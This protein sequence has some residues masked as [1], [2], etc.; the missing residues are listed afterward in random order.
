MCILTAVLVVPNAMRNGRRR[1]VLRR[2]K[3]ASEL[4]ITVVG[5]PVDRVS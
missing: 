1:I 2:A 4:R 3:D 5:S